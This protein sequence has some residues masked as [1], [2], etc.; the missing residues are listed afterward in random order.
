MYYKQI[1]RSYT[2]PITELK[3]V[4]LSNGSFVA[5]YVY[6]NYI[7][8]AFSTDGSHWVLNGR[9]TTNAGQT[10]ENSISIAAATQSNLTGIIFKSDRGSNKLWYT[11]S[12]DGGETWMDPTGLPVYNEN[13]LSPALVFSVVP[14]V[15]YIVPND[16]I[17]STVWFLSWST[18]KHL[19]IPVNSTNIEALSQDLC[20]FADG[21][22]GLVVSGWNKSSIKKDYDIW[23]FHSPN[24]NNWSRA[25]SVATSYDNETL[26]AITELEKGVVMVAYAR[27]NTIRAKV[28]T[29]GGL[30]WG[31]EHDIHQWFY[32]APFSLITL[33]SGGYLLGY[34]AYWISII[35]GNFYPTYSTSYVYNNVTDWW[36]Y[37]VAD[38]RAVTYADTDNDGREEII[39]GAGNILSIFSYNQTLGM[40]NLTWSSKK[41]GAEIMDIAVS[42]TNG[43]GLPDIIVTA[44]GG[45][46]YGF[47]LADKDPPKVTF[48]NVARY[49]AVS[50]GEITVTVRVR[51]QSKI[52]SVE[53]K[54]DDSDWVVATR[55]GENTYAVTFELTSPGIHYI[56]ARARDWNGLQ[57][58][59]VSIEI[60]VVGNTFDTQSNTSVT[61]NDEPSANPLLWY[62]VIL[63]LLSLAVLFILTKKKQERLLST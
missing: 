9:I 8:S 49:S 47:E 30:K 14:V 2:T 35:G 4:Q 54:L 5:V 63:G 10:Y 16:G 61:H 1:T 42:D 11:S 28:S 46:V 52:K 13:F 6:N 58:D 32:Y 29:N 44:K 60:N 27:G 51:D 19:D 34:I 55:S 36:Y 41:L 31:T 15:T 45:Y 21:S 22:F 56:S 23:Y 17:Y 18:P 24:L 20:A 25:T 7:Y 50:T 59:A 12:S 26:P 40:Y 62:G 39:V 53:L 33:N 57:S 38:V 3:I 43:N 48:S 37:S